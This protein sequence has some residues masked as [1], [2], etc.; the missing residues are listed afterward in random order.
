MVPPS[1]IY[2]PI[3]LLC[4]ALTSQES[5]SCDVLLILESGRRFQLDAVPAYTAFYVYKSP[6]LPK[7]VQPE[8]GMVA[9][10]VH[11]AWNQEV[12]LQFGNILELGGYF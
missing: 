7:R 2:T 9:Y 5:G 10:Q 11:L 12:L 4:T 3:G 8:L 6:G 1:H